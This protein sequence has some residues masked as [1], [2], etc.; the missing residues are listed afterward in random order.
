MLVVSLAQA[1]DAGLV[2]GKAAALGEMIRAGENVPDGFV[3]TT[4]AHRQGTIPR[5]A[6]DA[7]YNELGGGAVAVR[8]SATAEDLPGASF[9]GQHDTFLDVTDIDNLLAAIAKCWDSVRTPRAVAYRETHDVD[10]PL[11]AVIVQRMVQAST[12]GVL[13]TADPVTGCRTSMLVEAANGPGTGVV[14]GTAPVVRSVPAETS[15]LRQAGER[16]QALFATPQDVEWAIDHAGEFWL[17]QS[18]PITT[19]FP[20]P[21]AHDGPLPRIYV[22]FG[23]VQGMLR[24]VTPMGMSSL[25]RMI[26]G[27]LAAL[28]VH[29]EVVDIGGRLYGDLSDLARSPSARKRLVKLMAVDF[30]PRAQAVME[31]VLADPRFAPAPKAEK[32]KADRSKSALGT[33]F[34][35]VTGIL[36]ALASPE[37]ARLRV[38]AAVERLRLS[39][40]APAGVTTL[41][42]RLA[43]V[44]ADDPD[45][46][47][48]GDL[49][50][51]IVAG[52]LAGAVPGEL[53][54]G[55]AAAD[56]IQTVL[57]GMPY[58][59]TIEMDLALWR[60]AQGAAAHRDL[61]LETP[62]TDLAARYLDGSLPEIGLSGFLE[63]YGH[64][65][66]AE[67]DLGVPRWSEDPAG[68]FAAIANYLRVTDMD[69]S[70]EA[71]FASAAAAGEAALADLARRVRRQRPVRGRLAVFLLRRARALSGLREYGKFAGLYRLSS[72][73]KQL[74]LIGSDLVGLGVLSVAG[75]IMFLTLDE[76]EAAVRSGADHRG[77]V[78]ARRATYR[79]E[80]RRRHVPVALLSDGTDVE[81]T[82][83]ASVAGDGWQGV[84]ASP[85]RVTG[86]ARI[87][88]DPAV[89]RIEPGDILVVSTTDPAW[90]P[91]FLTAGGLVSETGA[92]MAHGPTVAREYGIPAVISVPGATSLITEGELITVDG[93]AGTVSVASTA[94]LSA[95]DGEPD[96]ADGEPGAPDGQPRAAD[97]PAGSVGGS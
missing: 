61:L 27:M 8:S 80:S 28:G 29:A 68:L 82:L 45:D 25:Q 74:M 6:I 44:R 93:A 36:R 35:A 79:A 70:P 72:V 15:P 96:A 51:P 91:L 57:G 92:V 33:A 34:R 83:P 20:A 76:A 38:L 42:D 23:H 75:D 81:T 89:A 41:A 52:L 46:T 90:T 50:W 7:A 37:S 63:N 22:E 14:D 17:L 67:A 78:D 60:L 88:H 47:I 86:R 1:A 5:D 66:P 11:M 55:I 87:V 31:H 4:D 58:N 69:Q 65:G 97:T 10:E 40:P 94:G 39:A 71:R 2:G 43:F 26:T 95:A 84:G 18:R 59:V 77:L 64:R 48:A 73:R 85:G 12:A 9:A 19:L 49:T 62:P 13:F 53:L 32:S 16:L 24:P 21:P 54:K 3:V 56:E 30:G